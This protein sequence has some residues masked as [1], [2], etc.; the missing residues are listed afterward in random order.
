ML[1]EPTRGIDVGAK[2]EIYNLIN[3]LKKKGMGIIIVSSELPEIVG[4][5]DRAL[6]M[7]EG[8]IKAELSGKDISQ[9]RI[10]ESA[11]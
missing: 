8:Q 10:M 4:I 9:E 3:S 6:V 7:K 11:A 1:D 2:V 5:C